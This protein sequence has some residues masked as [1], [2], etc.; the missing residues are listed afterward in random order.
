MTILLHCTI[1]DAPER[2]PQPPAASFRR[3]SNGLN[4]GPDA[5]YPRVWRHYSPVIS[6]RSIVGDLRNADGDRGSHA[7]WNAAVTNALARAVSLTSEALRLLDQGK[8]GLTAAPHLD[9]AIH[10]LT[11]EL[12]AGE[13]TFATEDRTDSAS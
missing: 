10:L 2:R 11:A 12:K 1:D 13:A 3:L 4:P 6:V 9:L 8:V 5:V 7:L